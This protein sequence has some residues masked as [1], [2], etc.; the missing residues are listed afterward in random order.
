MKKNIASLLICAAFITGCVSKNPSSVSTS[1]VVTS[2]PSPV[3]GAPPILTTNEVTQTNYVYS[4]SPSLASTS[5]NIQ[6]NAAVVGAVVS[7]LYPPAAPVV[8]LAQDILTGIL[9]LIAAGSGWYANK[10]NNDAKTQSQAAAA[11]ASHIVTTQPAS[12]SALINNTTDA[13]GTATPLTAAVQ[14]HIATQQV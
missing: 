2:S 14:A 6:A 4:V 3:I 1:P 5:S 8:P 13:T 10:K 11:M 12:I 9:G 7:T